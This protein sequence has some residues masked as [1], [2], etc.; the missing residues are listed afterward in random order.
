MT[1]EGQL[2]TYKCV[3]LDIVDGDTVDIDIDLGFGVWLRDQRVRVYG[4]DAP[5]SRT[6]DDTEKIFGLLSK[7]KVMGLIPVGSKQILKTHLGEERGKF[8]RILGEFYVDYGGTV[9]SVSEIMVE[10]HY[11][12]EYYGQSKKDIESQHKRN[13]EALVDKGVV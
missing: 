9:K 3:I 2:Y 8:G 4:I 12:V 1:R 11:A 13:R 5:E 6:S 10:N 7:D